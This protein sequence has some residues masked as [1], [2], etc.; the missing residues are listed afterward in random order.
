MATNVKV[1]K[2]TLTPKGATLAVEGLDSDKKKATG[3]VTVLKEN[4][5]WKIGEENW[6]S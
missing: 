3:T 1:T 4:G 2:E 5:A 6:K